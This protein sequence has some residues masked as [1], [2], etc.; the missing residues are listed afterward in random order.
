MR[1]RRWALTSSSCALP[2]GYDTVLEQRG[3]NLSMGQ[4]ALASMARAVVSDPRILILDEATANMDSE[5]EHRLQEALKIVLKGRTSM[6]I[7]HRLSTITGSDKIVVLE[8]GRIVDVGTHQELL[9]R[10]GVYAKLYAMNFD[11]DAPLDDWA[12]SVTI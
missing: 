5:T 3:A 8:R 1:R 7:A 2:H 4:R 9:D 11:E 10:G 6:I 12:G